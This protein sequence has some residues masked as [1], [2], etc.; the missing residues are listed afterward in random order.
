VLGCI[1][2][3]WFTNSLGNQQLV[4]ASLVLGGTLLVFVMALPSGLLPTSQRLIFKL[5]PGIA[6]RLKEEAER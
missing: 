5:H 4:N 3:M 1:L 2:L 6:A